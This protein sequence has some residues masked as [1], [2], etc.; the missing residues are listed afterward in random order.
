MNNNSKRANPSKPPAGS[1]QAP[2]HPSNLCSKDIDCVG[3]DRKIKIEASKK[4]KDSFNSTASYV[5]EPSGLVMLV[6]DQSKKRSK[7]L[8]KVKRN[9]PLMQ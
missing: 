5:L 9:K 6:K 1:R 7:K 2:N 3:R 4:I 8:S